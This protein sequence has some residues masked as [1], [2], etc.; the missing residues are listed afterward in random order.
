MSAAGLL[1]GP[2]G[3]GALLLRGA[4][5][6]VALALVTVPFGFGVGL[7]L[8]ALMLLSSGLQMM[9]FSNFLVDLIWGGF[10]LLS[11]A[12]NAWRGRGRRA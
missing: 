3:W 2:D 5:V 8:A 10:L 12:L 11:V 4:L 6:T 1:F 9:R 7:A